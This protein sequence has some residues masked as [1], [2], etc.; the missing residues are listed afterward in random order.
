MSRLLRAAVRTPALVVLAT[1]CVATVLTAGGISASDASPLSTVAGVSQPPL[2][3]GVGAPHSNSTAH[4]TYT[5]STVVIDPALL[6]RSLVGV[7]PDGS[8]Y[9]FSAASGP[10]ADLKPGKVI[11]LY[12]FDA[13]VVT[14]VSHVAGKL[15]VATT[16]ATLSQIVQSGTID[17]NSPPDYAGAF[18]SDID[19]TPLTAA[20]PATSPATSGRG[21]AS[22][23]LSIRPAIKGWSYSGKDSTGDLTYQ[24]YLAGDSDGLH[25]YGGFCYSS[26]GSGSVSGTCGGPLSLT[27]TVNGLLSF[28]SQV[29]AITVP[30][31]LPPKGSYSL[32]GFTARLQVNYT[33]KRE[34][35]S[36][37][38]GKLK[39][40]ALPFSFEMPVCPPPGFC[41]GIPLYTKFTI[42]LLVTLGISGKNSVMQGGFTVLVAGSGSVV[43]QTGFKV[44]A[45]SAAGFHLSGKFLPGT[46]LTLGG[47]GAEV[48]LQSKLA[49]GLGIR[50]FNAMFYLSFIS[51][52]GQVTGSA[53]AGQFCQSY[54]ADFSITGGIEAQLWIFKIPLVSVTLWSKKESMTQ[55]GC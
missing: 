42:S 21:G 3:I 46:S 10:L 27:G 54:Y 49:L 37:I 1:S 6:H 53:V 29:A 9:T 8:T 48:A 13:G 51:A 19:T 40:E 22:P 28:N 26:N 30:K 39:A 5:P 31:G 20:E 32:S 41:A 18:G 33:A 16:P 52:I 55:P 35:G 43:D 15:V 4:V 47:S 36:Q 11:L 23:E 17:V 38:A 2:P 44:I 24:I 34:D 7:S 45:G 14:K 12:G 50:S 25:T